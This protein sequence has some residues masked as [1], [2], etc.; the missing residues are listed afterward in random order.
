MNTTVG[1]LA[2]FLHTIAPGHLQED[3]DNSGLITGKRTDVVKGCLFCLDATEDVINECIALGCNVVI[4]HHPIVFRGLKRFTG[5]HYV[6]R[7]IIKALKN[8]ISI[9]AVHTNLDNVYEGGVNGMIA[10]KLNMQRT[11]ILSP[12]PSVMFNDQPVGAGMTGYLDV[13]MTSSDFLSY[14]SEKMELQVIKHTPLVRK[15]IRKI[16]VCGG[17]GSFLLS[18][19]KKAGADIY[20]SS[21]FKYHEYF[22]AENDIIIAD[23][24]HFE[25]EKYTIQLLYN[26][27]INKFSNFAAHCTNVVTN[28]IKY[29]IK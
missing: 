10:G 11:E 2:D 15:E 22:E 20:I 5:D 27:I 17:S 8:D 19:A 6:E 9:L 25:S 29:F 4:A 18:A 21:D 12:K 16:A 1:Q 14:L 13:P 23:I 3:Y 28:P 26:H 24:G 7:V